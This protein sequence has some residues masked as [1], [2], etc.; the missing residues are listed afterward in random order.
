VLTV[1]LFSSAEV[2]WRKGIDLVVEA[3]RRLPDIPFD[4]V[5]ASVP[6]QDLNEAYAPPPN[7]AFH[8]PVERAEL[9]T[10]YQK[11][12]VYLQL[13]R[14][15]GMPNVIC[16]AMLCGAI[17]V[18]SE[19]FGIPAAMGDVGYVVSEPDVPS[20]AGAIEDALA[21]SPAKRKEAREH[22]ADTFT[23]ERRRSTLQTLL[24]GLMDGEKIQTVLSG[25]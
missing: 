10:W 4:I 5:G 25:L 8:G 1:G 2:L 9:E 3:A 11:A 21:A 14:A 17:P 13:S 24:D 15:E 6:E 16:E 7:V 22:I 12:S 18:G 20:I 19:V 23:L